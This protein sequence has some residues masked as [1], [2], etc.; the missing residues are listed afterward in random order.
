MENLLKIERVDAP[1]AHV[2]KF[3]ISSLSVL[4]EA[5]E[6]DAVI[7]YLSLLRASMQPAVTA[8]PSRTQQYVVELDPCWHIEKHPLY[9]GAVIF[10]RHTGLG[11][12]GFALPDH[13]LAKMHASIT[14][15]FETELSTGTLPH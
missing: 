9:T 1:D 10:F 2:V 7:Q 15:Y 12:S 8:T 4:L 13:S 14:Q 3:S 11:W 5:T 6:V